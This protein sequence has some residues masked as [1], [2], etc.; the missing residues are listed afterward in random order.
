MKNTGLKLVN[1]MAKVGVNNMNF[2][3]DRGDDVRK[4]SFAYETGYIKRLSQSLDVSFGRYNREKQAGHCISPEVQII[5]YRFIIYT[6]H[7]RFEAY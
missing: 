5:F 1:T 7:V 4:S 6:V 3:L 2:V